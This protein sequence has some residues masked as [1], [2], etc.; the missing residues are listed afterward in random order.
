MRHWLGGWWESVSPLFQLAVVHSGLTAACCAHQDHYHFG[1]M[2]NHFQQARHFAKKLP[3]TRCFVQDHL[4]AAMHHLI[5]LQ[6]PKEGWTKPFH[7]LSLMF[8][9]KDLH[10]SAVLQ[11]WDTTLLLHQAQLAVGTCVPVD[12]VAAAWRDP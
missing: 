6:T 1:A 3:I 5:V 11:R 12:E 9:C 2:Q 7:V 4:G 10:P 8:L